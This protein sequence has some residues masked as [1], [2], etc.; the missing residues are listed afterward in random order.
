MS[1]NSNNGCGKGIAVL[2]MS[3][4]IGMACI[5]ASPYC[6]CAFI[7]VPWMTSEWNN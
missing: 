3:I 5:F 1:S 2:G 4:G 6:A 7:F